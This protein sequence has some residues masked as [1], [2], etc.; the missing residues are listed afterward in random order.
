MKSTDGSPRIKLLYLVAIAALALGVYSAFLGRSVQ[1]AAA[2]N[3]A[4]L[5]RRIDQVEQRFYMVESRLNRLESNE[6]RSSVLSSPVPNTSDVE[7]QFLRTSIDGI[8]TRVG[9]LEC[10]VLRLDE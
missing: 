1:P 5:S 8:R 6:N 4:F 2:Q 10:G 3:D 7:L 9:E